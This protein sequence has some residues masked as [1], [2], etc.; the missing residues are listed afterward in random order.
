MKIC[1]DE[2]PS[3]TWTKQRNLF[4]QTE[5]QQLQCWARE[6]STYFG[7]ADINNIVDIMH[8]CHTHLNQEPQTM[9]MTLDFK[10][11]ICFDYSCFLSV[12]FILYL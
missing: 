10:Q 7:L 5:D 6:K 8:M 12:L 3:V 1:A 4:G 9:T 11:S 2:Q